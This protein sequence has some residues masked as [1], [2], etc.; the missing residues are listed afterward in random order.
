[1][2]IV[3]RVLTALVQAAALYLLADAATAPRSWPAT[4][5]SLYEPL[6]LVSVYIPLFVLFGLGQIRARP[7][8]IWLAVAAI[9]VAGLGYHDA[10]RG[11][12]PDSILNPE[13][14]P[15]FRL[16]L[17]L[18]AS[19]FV[20][21]VLV[22]DST[23]E[24]RLL[25]PYERH[26]DTAWKLGTQVV[27]AVVFV[28]VFWGILW[29]GAGLFTLV[30]LEFFDRVISKPWFAYPATTLAIALS[31][32]VTDVQPALIRG[33]R[34]VALTLFSW[35]LPLL[36]MILLGFLGSLSFISLEALWKTRFAT[37]LL[38]TAAGLLVFLINCCYQ[39]GE[40][41]PSIPRINRLAGTLGSIAL[42]PLVG[43]AIWALA[44]R[45]AQYGWTVERILAA[46]V[47]VVAACYAVGY[48][49]AAIGSP[50]WLKRVEV[51]NFVTAYVFLGLVLVLFSPIA[52][53][54]RLMVADQVAR[55]KAGTV[56][57][58]Q[59]D[60][61]TLKFD[62]ARWGLA[63]LGELSQTQDLSSAPTINAKAKQALAQA[64]RWIGDRPPT[65]DELAER[66]SVYPSGRSL[67]PSFSA[68]SAGPMAGINLNCVQMRSKKCI[69]RFVTLRPGE[70]EAILL[71]DQ[72]VGYV[73]EQDSARQWR[74]TAQLAGA[75]NCD[76]LRQGVESGAFKLETHPWP[77]LV[78]GD[79]RLGLA[80]TPSYT[81]PPAGR[82]P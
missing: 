30:G 77:D 8:A 49:S 32:H 81:C 68:T 11:R 70:G 79:Q 47:I 19:L 64:N 43:L 82:A 4:V 10:T 45:V 58:E 27:L 80:P 71:L 24:R 15:W 60:F 2:L 5:P 75:V 22:V 21:H 72:F 9:L 20:A 54:G 17:A 33:V 16:W 12:V 55:L 53:P 51:T 25:P 37:G 56:R 38:L 6:L 52:D 13:L 1:M 59:F 66:V 78:V 41:T 50:R 28:G 26:F 69:A 34:S 57:P 74:K 67:P 62:G 61:S 29:L 48:A 18:S 46:A 36:V 40:A 65:R 42:L 63:A 35:L 7:L 23:V 39:D 73:F 76:A 31:I 3:A 14:G 44:L